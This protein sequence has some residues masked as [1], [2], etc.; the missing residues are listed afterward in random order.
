[1][2]I[3]VSDLSGVEPAKLLPDPAARR[4][5]FQKRV[6][7]LAIKYA[8]EGYALVIH[9]SVE[10][11]NAQVHVDGSSR[12]ALHVSACLKT[13]EQVRQHMANGGRTK[14]GLIVPPGAK[15]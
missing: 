9:E 7:Q 5:K 12:L 3:K 11:G 14:G 13:A 10:G 1:M 15:P 4:R 6:R 8:I 2:T